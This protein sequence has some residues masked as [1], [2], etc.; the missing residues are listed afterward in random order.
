MKTCSL[1]LTL[2]LCPGL[3]LAG[4][5]RAASG[6]ALSSPGYSRHSASRADGAAA[7]LLTKE[8]VGAILGQPVT[9]IEGKGTNVTYKTAVLM[10]ETSIE[11]EQQRDVADA[12]RSMAGARTATGFLGGKAEEVPG[13]GDEAIFGAMSTLYFRK[14]STFMHVQPPN[15][16]Q[17]A[18]MKAMEK[19]RDAP[20]GS[21][22]QKK[23]MENLTEVQKTDPTNA[24]LKGGDDMQGALAVVK[25]SSQKQGT[26]YET[27]ARAMAVA[28]ATKLLEKV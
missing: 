14:G 18:G 7:P 13:L 27:D 1:A 12:V 8:E 5:N 21:D 22:E 3:F 23:A 15:L 26:Q 20:M 28:L 10:L 6:T 4:C 11:T 19:V 9:S 16:Q 2:A 24:G 17:I 25:A